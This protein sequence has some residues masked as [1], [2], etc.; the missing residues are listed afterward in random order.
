MDDSEILNI[1]ITDLAYQDNFEEVLSK[2]TI[3][4][5]SD[6]IVCQYPVYNMIPLKEISICYQER[7]FSYDYLYAIFM[8]V[9]G[10]M[11]EYTVSQVVSQKDNVVDI[12]LEDAFQKRELL[13]YLK[14]MISDFQIS[15]VRF[16]I[17]ESH[18][19]S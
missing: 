18:L 15:A 13:L 1:C 7:A 9:D 4:Q 8:A 12:Y 19:Q 10:V 5:T 17:E 2:Q 6:E 3:E 16:I 11:E 14:S